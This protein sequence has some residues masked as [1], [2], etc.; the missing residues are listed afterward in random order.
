MLRTMEVEIDASGQLHPVK[1]GV[2]LPRAE[3]F[4]RGQRRSEV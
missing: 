1:P 2:A 4:W 3:P